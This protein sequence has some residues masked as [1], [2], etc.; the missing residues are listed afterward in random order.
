MK[1]NSTDHSDC[2]LIILSQKIW[3]TLLAQLYFCAAE[4]DPFEAVA[5]ENIFMPLTLDSYEGCL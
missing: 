1:C 5:R 2:K 4:P 3:K